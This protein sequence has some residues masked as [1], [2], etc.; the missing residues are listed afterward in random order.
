MVKKIT[1]REQGIEDRRLMHPGREWVIGLVLSAIVTIA[2]GSYAF[3]VF[4]EYSGISVESEAVEV[5][6]L[7]YDRASA[8]DAIEWYQALQASYETLLDTR[9][10]TAAP[11]PE[12]EEELDITIETTVDDV[13]LVE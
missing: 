12:P 5:D 4:L 10:Q 8:I 3:L 9:P 1:R 13:L 11:E 7:Q 2:G 6:Q